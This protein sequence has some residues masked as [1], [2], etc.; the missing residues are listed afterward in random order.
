MID[1]TKF[2]EMKR[3]AVEISAMLEGLRKSLKNTENK[4]L[5]S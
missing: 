2:E 5:K 4:K 3:E 1:K